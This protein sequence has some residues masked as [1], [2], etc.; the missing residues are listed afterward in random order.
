M[1]LYHEKGYQDKLVHSFGVPPGLPK[2]SIDIRLTPSDEVQIRGGN[3]EEGT[4]I[5]YDWQLPQH[6]YFDK[7]SF[8]HV[9]YDKYVIVIIT[10]IEPKPRRILKKASS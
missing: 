4:Y 9:F 5:H 10:D 7:A 8:F 2:E 3:K 1:K 6:M